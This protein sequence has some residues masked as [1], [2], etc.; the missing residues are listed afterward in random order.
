MSLTASSA[1]LI[2]TDSLRAS[3]REVFDTSKEERTALWTHFCGYGARLVFLTAH[4]LLVLSVS[5]ALEHLDQVNW[6]LTFLP[7]WIGDALSFLLAVGSMFASFP[8]IKLCLV[9]RSP[10]VNDNPSML[11]EVLPEIVLAIPGLLL[12]LLA[13]C[14]EYSLC[15]YLA[16]AQHGEP[17][18]LPAATALL[19]LVALLSLCQGAL[20]TPNSAFWLSS[21]A[22]LLVSAVCFAATRGEDSAGGQA[23][24]VLPCVLAVAGLLLASVWRM[25]RYKRDVVEEERVL[26]SVE[27]LLLASLLL[28]LLAVLRAVAQDRLEEAG[29]AGIMVG[30]VLCLLAIPRARICL[31]EARHGPLEDRAFCNQVSSRLPDA[32]FSL[33]N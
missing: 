27:A 9:E 30:I 25:R 19:I 2:D 6:W 24:V 31:L 16:S 33:R 32:S 3:A 14:S 17:R 7:I 21:G 13:F 10:R 11:T 8:Y 15:G 18:S 12:L 1:E 26:L 4:G 28:A 20:F 5:V 22:G 29:P 23:F